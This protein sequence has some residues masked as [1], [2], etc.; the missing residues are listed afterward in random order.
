LKTAIRKILTQRKAV[1]RKEQSHRKDKLRGM[2]EASFIADLPY[3]H[4][5][6]FEPIDTGKY[7]PAEPVY[8]SSADFDSPYAAFSLF[9]T[10]EM[11]SQ[12]ADNTNG[13][14]KIWEAWDPPSEKTRPWYDTNVAEMKVFA[15][16][17][18]YM[19]IH[20]EGDV[21]IYW[22]T[23]MSE[24]PIHTCASVMSRIRY[25]QLHRFFHVAV[26]SPREDPRNS[27]AM[28]DEQFEAL[29]TDEKET[30]WWYKL[31]P[32]VTHFRHNCQVHWIPGDRVAIDEMMI[33]FFGSSSHTVKMQNKPIKM[34]YKIWACC[35]QGYLFFFLFYSRNEGTG[36]LEKHDDL[37]ATQSMVWQMSKRLPKNGRV[38]T[39]YMDN[40]FTSVRL[41]RMLR[42][43]GI[44]ACGTT[45]TNNDPSYPPI[46]PVF[47]EKYAD[48]LPWGTSIAVPVGDVLC[49]GWIDNNAVLALSTVH[50]VNDV[51]DNVSRP[52]KR[53]ITTSSNAAVTRIPFAGNSRALLDIPR[54]INDYNHWMNGVDTADQHRQGYH[55][56]RRA[57]R[58]WLCL[59]YWILDH[60]V[61]NAFKIAS[62]SEFYWRKNQ[63]GRFRDFLWQELF[64]FAPEAVR[65]REIDR[66]PRRAPGSIHFHNRVELHPKKKQCAMCSSR[67]RTTTGLSRTPSPEKR[68]FGDTI[69]VNMMPQR[70][71]SEKESK[72]ARRTTMGC[73]Q[74][75]VSLCTDCW[76]SYHATV[77]EARPKGPP[78]RV[79]KSTKKKAA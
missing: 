16:V 66:L 2:D 57:C 44:G 68:S 25:S 21:A 3:A 26:P 58:N 14:A 10:E 13:Y 56:Q 79:W 74:C 41:F 38:Y 55:T 22:N 42:E 4:T 48:K 39:I 61:I 19:G 69:S 47:R 37:S 18:I 60:A 59:F 51:E 71:R 12:L 9:F 33:K 28:T 17:L 53:P 35:E 45:R 50:T 78:A 20:K 52:R 62:L 1:V 76:E 7:R 24:G 43:A 31:E 32:F 70:Q 67:Y 73:Q 15:G 5:V 77:P 40:L 65:L 75:Q 30:S 34:G 46:F 64:R 49:F 29:P 36:E 54:L 23:D 72:R 8:P 27:D 11:W 63:H 6:S